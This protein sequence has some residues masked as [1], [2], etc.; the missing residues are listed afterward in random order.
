VYRDDA[1]YALL[2]ESIASG[3]AYG[4][5]YA[6][7]QPLPSQF[8]IGFPLILAPLIKFSNSL[9]A[10][11]SVSLLA[12][13]VNISILFWMWPSFTKKLPYWMAIVTIAL[14]AASPMVVGHASMIMS[15]PIFTTL[16]LLSLVLAERLAGNRTAF[17]WPLLL[18]I[19]LSFA[20]LVRTAGVSLAFGMVLTLILILRLSVWKHLALM[21]LGGALL[22]A[23]LLVFAPIT[24]DNFL[25][26]KYVD[27]LNTEHILNKG[28]DDSDDTL[29]LRIGYGA[30]T[31]SLHTRSLLVPIGGGNKEVRWGQQ[32]GINDLRSIT[33]V[34][35]VSVVVVG[36]IAT[37]LSGNLSPF[38]L[39]SSI[40]Y[41]GLLSIWPWEDRRFLYP[42]F[43]FIIIAFLCGVYSLA[44]LF[45]K[46]IRVRGF[47]TT[48]PKT[49]VL[50]C[51]AILLVISVVKSLSL[52][53]T[54]QIVGDLALAPA[55]L[56]DNTP[57]DGIVATA[58]PEVVFL[59][60]GRKTVNYPQLDSISDFRDFITDNKI[61]YVMIEPSRAW[62]ADNILKYDDYTVQVLIPMVQDL[63]SNQELTLIYESADDQMVTVYQ[64]ALV[65]AD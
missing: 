55:W 65:P 22:I 39:L 31:A 24:F 43:P 40:C 14:F 3:P 49:A 1:S 44:L 38:I 26:G 19:T 4:L 16:Y 8:P 48:W 62:S 61:D 54:E 5:I 13:L 32:L 15:E 59:Y 7:D 2:A 18:G 28:E 63:V 51:S 35:V 12:T 50:A 56:Q 30:Q 21:G 42:I 27:E 6:P 36:S 34:V 23:S 17:Y 46:V 41:L 45:G 29:W 64:T 60:S 20:V 11:K 52:P 10:M 53:A 57:E 9:Q 47:D 25:P 37:L 33:I 58:S